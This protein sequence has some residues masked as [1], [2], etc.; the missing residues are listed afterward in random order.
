M[1]GTAAVILPP[2]FKPRLQQDPL[3]AKDNPMG[4]TVCQLQQIHPLWCTQLA[5]SPLYLEEK[6]LAA[7]PFLP[8]PVPTISQGSGIPLQ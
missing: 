1:K 2:R 4:Y 6:G 5:H 3:I 8:L 7:E